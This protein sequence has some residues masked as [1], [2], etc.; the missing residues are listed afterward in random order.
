MDA[1]KRLHEKGFVHGDVRDVNVLIKRA[2]ADSQLPSV[3]LVNF[4]W[5]R[6]MGKMAYPS[7][8]N[9]REILLNETR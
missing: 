7:S 4:D 5:G 6:T 9:S 2:S 8:I 3:K 1:V